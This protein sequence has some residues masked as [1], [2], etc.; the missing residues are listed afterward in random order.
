MAAVVSSCSLRA[1][2]AAH[3]EPERKSLQQS[4][5]RSTAPFNG[6]ASSSTHTDAAAGQTVVVGLRQLSSSSSSSS[7]LSTLH[8]LRPPTQ[9]NTILAQQPKPCAAQDDFDDWDVDL[10]DLDECDGQMGQPPP[11]PAPSPSALTARPA[12]SAK[13]LRAPTCGGLQTPREVTAARQPCSSTNHNLPPRTLSSTHV[14]SPLPRPAFLPPQSPGVFPGLT[15]TSPAPSPISRTLIRPQPPPQR[16]WSTPRP[17]PQARGFFETVSPAPSS[18]SSSMN[19]T[20]LSP[21]PLHTPLLTNRLVQLV[22]A[23]NRLTKKRPHS[24]PHRTRTRR[25][26]GPAGFLPQQVGTIRPWCSSSAIQLYFLTSVCIF[27]VSVS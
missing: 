23:S 5:Q 22:S 15:A 2:T 8:S 26:P 4:A 17:S 14:R 6:T 1:P 25:F 16:L 11:P 24:E 19:S 12:S 7:S 3:T 13:T 21:H 10:A 18:S 27:Q 9:N 20:M